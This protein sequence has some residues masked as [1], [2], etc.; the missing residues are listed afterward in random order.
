MKSSSI[1]AASGLLVSAGW[2]FPASSQPAPLVIGQP[3]QHMLKAGTV[4][5]LKTVTELTTRGKKLRVGQRFDLEVSEPVTLNGVTIIP[6]GNRAIGEVTSVRNKGMWGRSGNIDVRLISVRVGDRQ[7]RLTGSAND[8]G[9]TGTAGVVGAVVLLPLAGFFMTGTSATIPPGSGI[10][11]YL[12]EDL[13]VQFA[14]GHAPPPAMVVA[15]PA[16]VAPIGG[17]AAGPG[18][19]AVPAV[20]TVQPAAVVTNADARAVGG[21]VEIGTAG[22]QT[23]GAGQAAGTT[24]P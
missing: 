10:A 15:V 4:V 20:A 6:V 11:G 2:A 21:S 7:I 24:T 18:A 22:E 16:T 8:K 13:P 17:A 14:A 5:P 9:V 1:F 19:A 23:A 12:D 3:T